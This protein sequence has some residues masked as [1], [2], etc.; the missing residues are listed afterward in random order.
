MCAYWFLGEWGCD[1]RVYVY[2][3]HVHGVG[4]GQGLGVKRRGDSDSSSGSGSEWE[5]VYKGSFLDRE[6]KCKRRRL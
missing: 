6:Y 1:E 5:D 4:M 2:P 3:S